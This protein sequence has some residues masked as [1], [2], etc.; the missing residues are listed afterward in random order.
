MFKRYR[1]RKTYEWHLDKLERL[2]ELPMIPPSRQHKLILMHTVALEHL[3]Q[4]DTESKGE[5]NA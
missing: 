5:E 4:S 2:H 1:R 3:T